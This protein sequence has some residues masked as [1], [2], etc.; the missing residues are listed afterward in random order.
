MRVLRSRAGTPLGQ[1]PDSKAELTREE[2]FRRAA[3]TPPK[4]AGDMLRSLSVRR[5]GLCPRISVQQRQLRAMT[6]A[7]RTLDVYGYVASPDPCMQHAEPTAPARIQRNEPS[8]YQLSRFTP[9]INCFLPASRCAP[10]LKMKR[11]VYGVPQ[12]TCVHVVGRR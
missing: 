11:G 3:S 5:R 12:L 7:S 6:A 10:Q 8:M 1:L 4:D 9:P 2:A